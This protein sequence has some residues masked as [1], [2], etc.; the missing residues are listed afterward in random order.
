MDDPSINLAAPYANESALVDDLRQGADPAYEH[1]VR[2][3]APRLLA[4]LSRMLSNSAD[5][6]E[7]LQETFLQAFKSIHRFEGQSLLSTWLHR[8]AVNTALM[9][10]RSKRRRPEKKISELL[11]TYESGFR[12]DVGPVWRET[13]SD[14]LERAEM[15]QLVLTSI[16]NLPDDHR[17]ILLLRDIEGMDTQ[18]A[19]DVLDISAGAAK[20]RL[21][22]ARQALREQL[23][24]YFA[25]GGLT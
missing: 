3:Y 18:Q 7:A 6:Q 19:A 2:T 15:R 1:M 23:V 13:P 20:T 21:H 16:D 10:L 9:K 14:E 5:A 17:A 11:P 25:E 22:R 12:P 24:P 8:I 4:V